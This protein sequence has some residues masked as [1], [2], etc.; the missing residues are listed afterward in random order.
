MD[1]VPRVWITANTVDWLM[2]YALASIV[3]DVLA[4]HL[5]LG[6]RVAW[7]IGIQAIGMGVPVAFYLSGLVRVA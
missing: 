4:W 5:V 7:F 3:L 6:R 2:G 1:A